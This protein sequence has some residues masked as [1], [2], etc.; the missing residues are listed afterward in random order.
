[1][2]QPCMCDVLTKVY[3]PPTLRRYPS[4]QC[5]RICR[6][7]IILPLVLRKVNNIS[8]CNLLS[9]INIFQRKAR[10]SCENE[11]QSMSKR[12][13]LR[14]EFMNHCWFLQPTVFCNW[15]KYCR[16]PIRVYQSFIFWLRFCRMHSLYA[17]CRTRART[18]TKLYLNSSQNKYNFH[19]FLFTWSTITDRINFFNCTAHQL[20]SKMTYSNYPIFC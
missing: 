13:R 5:H 2:C 3:K 12:G 10:M 20:K 1:M 15:L 19:W 16:V 4:W 14:N 17:F 7:F 9:V 8:I 11:D 18:R 6:E